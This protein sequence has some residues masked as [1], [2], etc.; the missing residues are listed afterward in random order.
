MSIVALVCFGLGFVI[1][2][3]IILK[4]IHKAE[5]FGDV[6]DDENDLYE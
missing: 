6:W 1:F 5:D 3:A 4:N 2:G